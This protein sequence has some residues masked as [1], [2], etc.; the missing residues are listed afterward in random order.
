MSDIV[1]RS[2]S[3]PQWPAGGFVTRR[4]DDRNFQV[5]QFTGYPVSNVSAGQWQRGTIIRKYQPA[6]RPPFLGLVAYDPTR[7]D[8]WGARGL[9]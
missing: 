2:I 4:F 5:Q 3:E 1:V 9:E 6:F 7:P 8:T